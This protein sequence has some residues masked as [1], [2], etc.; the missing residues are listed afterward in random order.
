MKIGFGSVARLQG[1]L[2]SASRRAPGSQRRWPK[3]VSVA[4][5]VAFNIL[6]WGAVAFALVS[7]F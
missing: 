2:G 4:F 6:A 7:V 3:M 1:L 5:V